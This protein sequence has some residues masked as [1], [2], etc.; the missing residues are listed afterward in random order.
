MAGEVNEIDEQYKKTLDQN[1]KEAKEASENLI[2]ATNSSLEQQEQGFEKLGETYKE[3]ENWTNPGAEDLKKSA[4]ESV[5]AYDEIISKNRP[6]TKEEEEKIRKRRK[7]SAMWTAIGDGISAIASLGSTINYGQPFKGDK[8]MSERMRERW[9]EL[10]A[11]RKEK[12]DL[13]LNAIGKKNESLKD[14]YNQHRAEHKDKMEAQI[15]GANVNIELGKAQGENAKTVYNAAKDAANTAVDNAGKKHKVGTE[16]EAY[17]E[18]VRNHKVQESQAQQ[19][20]NLK[21]KEFE[22]SKEK[23][24]DSIV[25]NTGKKDEVLKFDAA[26][27]GALIAYAREAMKGEFSD[28]ST[29]RKTDDDYLTDLKTKARTNPVISECVKDIIEQGYSDTPVTEGG[30]G[31]R[32]TSKK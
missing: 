22:Y 6:L 12:Q 23:E 2:N 17:N 28:W 9:K 29:S 26:T 11:E 3:A 15:G 13:Y 21:K 10:D 7:R 24:M 31:S 32:D 5:R 1:S 19:S 8:T 27:K 30:L 4:D 14:I 16:R 25:V 20:L 18:T